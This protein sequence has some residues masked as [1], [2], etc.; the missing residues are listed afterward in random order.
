MSEASAFSFKVTVYRESRLGQELA[1]LRSG[2]QRSARIQELASEAL[3]AASLR[4]HATPHAQASA[5]QGESM[6]SADIPDPP[7][8]QHVVASI[9]STLFSQIEEMRAHG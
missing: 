9:A 3:Y 6:V 8:S 1:K 2:R 7:P 5:T 4:S